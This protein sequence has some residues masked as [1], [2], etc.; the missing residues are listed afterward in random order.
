MP[1]SSR[2]HNKANGGEA[3][4]RTHVQAYLIFEIPVLLD[5]LELLGSLLGGAGTCC[6]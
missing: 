5:L 3:R 6:S 4:G 2:P 1:R